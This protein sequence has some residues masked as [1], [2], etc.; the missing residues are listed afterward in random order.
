MVTYFLIVIQSL[1]GMLT[2][3]SPHL[4]F[5]LFPHEIAASINAEEDEEQQCEAPKRRAAVAEEGQWNTDDRREAQHH[6][7]IDEHMEEEDAQHTVAIDTSELERLS[8]GKVD[9]TEYQR[10][11][12]QQDTR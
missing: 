1:C 2:D 12:E 4:T 5:E 10:Q 9:E 8:L 6:A 7:H 11:E 3:P